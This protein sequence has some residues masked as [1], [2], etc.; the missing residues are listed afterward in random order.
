LLET[1]SLETNGATLH[2]QPD[3]DEDVSATA[4]REAAR[5]G[6]GLGELV[7]RSVADYIMKLKIYGEE[8]EPGSPELGRV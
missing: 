7:P 3:V 1:G 2:L 5:Q 4:I 8:E 6:A